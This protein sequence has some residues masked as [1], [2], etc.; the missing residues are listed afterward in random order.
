MAKQSNDK[1]LLELQDAFKKNNVSYLSDESMQLIA[2]YY[3]AEGES[4]YEHNLEN[5]SEEKFSHKCEMDEYLGCESVCFPL[6][7]GFFLVNRNTTE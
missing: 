6:S 2:Y 5:W 4:P 7:N 3:D 1:S